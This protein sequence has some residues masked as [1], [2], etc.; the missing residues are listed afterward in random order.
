MKRNI[1]LFTLFV[2]LFSNSSAKSN[3]IIDGNYK[4]IYK[5]AEEYFVNE[6][7]TAALPLYIK[8]DSMEKDN[9]NLNFKIGFCYLKAA[10]YKT[11]S[12]PYLEFAI[13]DI[14]RLYEEGEMKEKQAPLSSLYYLAKAY[15]FNYEFDKA[16]DMY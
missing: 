3:S 16:I 7:Y 12:I 6:N 5:Q 11:K 14:A 10:T 9:H 2:L 8:L 15:H 4:S 13:K 1:L